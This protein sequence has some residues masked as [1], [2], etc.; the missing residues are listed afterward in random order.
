MSL[1]HN[2]AFREASM[3][4]VLLSRIQFGL[5]TAFHI[6]FPTLTI[7]LALYLVVVEWLWLRSQNAIYYRMYRFWVRIFAIHFA[8]GVVSGITLEF[9]FGTNFARFS[10]A[11]SNVFAPLMAYEGMT[12]FFLEAGFLGIMLFGWKKVSPAVHFISTCLVAVGASLSAFWIVAANAWMQT[13][14]GYELINGRF[15]VTSF[16]DAIFNP[17]FPTHLAH[18]LLA[19]YETAAF[20]VAG[21]CAW[22]LLKKQNDIFYRRSLSLAL[23]MAAVI[24]PLQAVVGDFKGQNV[25]QYQPAKL[26][27]MEAHWNTNT[28]GGAA[29]V[30]FA[31]PDMAAEKNLFEVT[32]PGMLSLLTTHS[33]NGRV[34]GLKEFPKSDRPNAAI[35]FWSFRIMVGIGFLFVAVMIWAGFLSLRKRL[36][37]TPIFY[38]T[39][40]AVQ[41][42]GFVATVIGWITA[43]LGRQPWTVYGLMRTK[44][45]VSPIAAGNVVWSLA[46]FMI[47]FAVLGGS[48]FYFT[49]KTLHSGPDLTSPIPHLQFSSGLPPSA[50]AKSFDEN[51]EGD[52]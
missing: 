34:S 10:Q 24:A 32:I 16:V 45:S 51:R 44:D 14:A 17:S 23:L 7:G 13:P 41:P 19:S 9:E 31:F 50:D 47:F 1:H 8:V 20:A 42:L 48:Y 36:F 15:M 43:E 27:A 11:V 6:I 21:I 29:F 28:K 2:H 22:F 5:T 38:K 37:D 40:V 39:L 25:A 46:M 26:A 49:L 35:T 18:M 33:I 4:V 12:A 30:A 3:D 52:A